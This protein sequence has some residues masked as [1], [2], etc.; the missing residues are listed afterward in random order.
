MKLRNLFCGVMAAAMA[1]VACDQEADLG[2]PDITLSANEIVLPSEAG[3]TT[4]TVKAT[5]DWTV[6]VD[7]TVEW[8]AIDPMGGNASNDDQ[9]VTLS[10]FAN[11]GY[12][13]E[14]SVAFTIGLKTKYLTVTQK[15]A[16]G[17]ADAL[18]IYANDMD[19][20]KVEKTADGYWPYPDQTDVWRNEKGSGIEN[21][22]YGSS[23]VTVRSVSSTT[24]MWFPAKGGSYFSIQNIALNSTASLKLTFDAIHG[25]NNG[26][27]KV[28]STSAFK[29]FVSKDAEK[30]VE[31]PYELEVKADDQFDA[32]SAA[33]TVEGVEALSVTFQ[34]LGAE[35]GYR[36]TNISLS[37]YEGEGATAVDF[38]AATEMN[39]TATSSGGNNN[40]GNN[41]GGSDNGGNNGGGE[42]APP[43]DAF[44]VESFADGIGKFTIEDKTR[45]SELEYVWKH[46]EY[47]GNKYMRASAYK[48]AAF[49]SESWLISPEVDLTNATAAYLSF[50]HT[51][52]FFSDASKETTVWASKDGAEWTQL[53]VPNYTTDWVWVFS[54]NI[55]LKDFVGGKMKFAFKYLSSASNAPTWE[56]KNICIS[57]SELSD[58]SNNGG[59]SDGDNTGGNTGGGSATGDGTY[60]STISW[61]C[62]TGAYD[63]GSSPKQSGTFNGTEVSNFLKLGKSDATGSAV[64]KIPAGTKKIGFY[65]VGW[66]G[67]TDAKLKF[68]NDAVVAVRA[69]EG[70]TGNPPY[71]ITLSDTEDYYYVEV[72]AASDMNL[73]VENVSKRVILVGLKAI[74]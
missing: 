19:N 45:P 68:S 25:S 54:G 64:L 61:T 8:L 66:K 34:F 57:P 71:T 74:E 12:D 44:F 21:V 63:A 70:A 20:G 41:N 58:N 51:G 16:Q 50:D 37:A 17:S 56:V 27:K 38:A 40:G 53:T 65:A 10:Y 33:F 35:D 39:F 30:W 42:V 52:K 9:T 28:F 48:E 7:E 3:D 46:E 23:G 32:A 59:S 14:V 5:L 22:Q 6:N 69:N 11:D 2:A 43:A 60:D 31:L 62:N 36:L 47:N 29:V 1:F 67:S 13:R 49:A 4:I 72:N 15:G 24:N 18:I 55:D 26:Y 73:T